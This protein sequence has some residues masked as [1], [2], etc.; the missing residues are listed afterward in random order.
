MAAKLVDAHP[1]LS[2]RDLIHLAV[3]KRLGVTRI[4]TTDG[5]FQ[6]LPIIER[7]DPAYIENWQWLR[8]LEG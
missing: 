6:G 5:G 3:M 7:L 8:R 1:R 2:A 4:V